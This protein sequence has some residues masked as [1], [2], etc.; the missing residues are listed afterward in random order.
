MAIAGLNAA[1][2]GLEI[3]TVVGGDATT[4]RMFAS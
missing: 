4:S 1:C 2:V 3:G